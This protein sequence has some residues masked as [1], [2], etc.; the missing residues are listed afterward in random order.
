MKP[1]AVRYM[2]INAKN[3]I[4]TKQQEFSTKTAYEKALERLEER[5]DFYRFLAFSEPQTDNY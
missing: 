2:L 3:Q 5:S 1:Y 4:V